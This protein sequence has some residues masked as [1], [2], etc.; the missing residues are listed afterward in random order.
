VTG[1]G[2]VL[3]H[4]TTSWFGV[5]VVGVL[6]AIA[7]RQTITKWIQTTCLSEQFQRVFYHLTNI[8]CKYPQLFEK[9]LEQI[10]EYHRDLLNDFD[11]NS[12]IST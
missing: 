9:M 6:L 2:L 12:I 1:L 7:Q 3:T 10:L 4:R 8:G 11:E 5:L